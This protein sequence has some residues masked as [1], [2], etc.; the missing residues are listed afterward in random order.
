MSHGS[1]ILSMLQYPYNKTKNIFWA[2]LWRQNIH[3]EWPTVR[4][5][6]YG[7]NIFLNEMKNDPV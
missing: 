2:R 1:M 5:T 4:T 7:S 6:K 3:D